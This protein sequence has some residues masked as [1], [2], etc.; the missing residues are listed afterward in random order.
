[1][2]GTLVRTSSIDD[3]CF[4]KAV[5]DHWGIEGIDVDWSRYQYSTD[6]GISRQL[7]EEHYGTPPDEGD[8]SSSRFNTE[9]PAR[10]LRSQGSV[11]DARFS[12]FYF[13]SVFREEVKKGQI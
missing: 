7:Y 3:V 12:L 13:G 2:D 9:G 4:E 5:A 1:M 11:G 10:L 8:I 6:S